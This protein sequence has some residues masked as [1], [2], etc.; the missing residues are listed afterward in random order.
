MHNPN[1][2]Y[3]YKQHPQ[4]SQPRSTL[5]RPNLLCLD[6]L[7][8]IGRA[9]SNHVESFYLASDSVHQLLKNLMKQRSAQKSL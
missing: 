5:G 1:H 3:H 6:H 9:S 8:Q 2:L 7:P 4:H